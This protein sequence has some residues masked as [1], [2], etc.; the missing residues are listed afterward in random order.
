MA[1]FCFDLHAALSAPVLHEFLDAVEAPTSRVAY[2][3]ALVAAL[4][5][6]FADL[7]TVRSAL[8]AEDVGHELLAAVA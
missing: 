4:E 5:L 8:V 3:L 7:A 2:F 6:V 1:T